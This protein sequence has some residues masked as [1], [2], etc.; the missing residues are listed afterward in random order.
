MNF[1][2][3]FEYGYAIALN[4]KIHPIVNN[5]FDFKKIERFF[6]PIL[7]VGIGKYTKNKLAL[8]LMKKRFWEK[9]IQD[10]LFNFEET[11]L[12]NDD[13]KID[14][15]HLLYLSNADDQQVS[16]AIESELDMSSINIIYDKPQEDTNSLIWYSKQIKRSYAVIIDMG[17]SNID[18]NFKHFLKYAL[19]AGLSIGSGRRTLILSSVHSKRPADIISIIKTYNAPKDARKYVNKFINHHANSFA[20][21]NAYKTTKIAER[22]SVFDQIDLGEHVAENDLAFLKSSYIS[23]PQYMSLDK[24]GYKL[25]IG[26]KGT[27]KTAAFLVFK[28]IGKEKNEVVINQFFDKYNLNDIYDLTLT[29]ETENDKNKIVNAFWKFIIFSIICYHV[30]KDIK[31]A[32]KYVYA[33]KLD[34]DNEFLNFA[35]SVGFFSNGKSITEN[36]LDIIEQIRAKGEYTVK[37]IQTEFYQNE[38][39]KLRN[40]VINYLIKSQKS[41]YLNIDGLDSNLT[42][43]NDS[44]II[45][46]ILYNLHEVCASLFRKKLQNIYIN[47]FIR[48]DL[49]DSFKDKITEKD[50]INK[51]FFSWSD[52]TLLRLINTRLQQ[53]SINHILDLLSEDLNMNI[54]MKKMNKYVFKRPRDY[55][56]IFNI[57][58][59]LARYLK[60]DKISTKIFNEAL[61]YYSLHI[62]ESIEAELMSMPFR[63]ATNELFNYIKNLNNDKEK[64]PLSIF[65]QALDYFSLSESDKLQL[66]I[67]L[68]KNEILVILENNKPIEW[69]NLIDPLS[70]LRII[71]STQQR[72]Y[73]LFHPILQTLL[74][75]HY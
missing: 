7:G 58:I 66:L 35:E 74:D 13:T 53:N 48:T 23:N 52:E 19:V 50:K 73:L 25:I 43:Q 32:N 9:G 26:R 8:K 62:N 28:G 15:D 67:F 24:P 41:L 1:N 12:L 69:N 16:E 71:I 22:S 30:M 40:A 6:D 75:R 70:K 56:Y 51:V 33:D 14:A 68:L 72:V 20:L 60:E 47:L 17:L 4:K 34:F 27:G 55:I 2:V 38:I 18:D 10:F 11:D 65:S 42:L 61:E 36:L 54:F 31:S 46:L 39:L 5:N 44:K 45:S 37:D 59:Q 64:I 29:F 3:I 63:I 49:Y 57:F 21:I